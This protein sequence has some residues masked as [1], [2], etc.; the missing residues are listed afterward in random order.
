MKF[1]DKKIS[2][3]YFQIYI[4]LSSKEKNQL[5]KNAKKELIYTKKE[6]LQEQINIYKN[7]NKTSNSDSS[8]EKLNTLKEE[9]FNLNIDNQKFDSKEIQELMCD[10]LLPQIFD[11]MDENHLIQVFDKELSIIG[12]LEDNSSLTM[13]YSFCYIRDDY[14]LIYPTTKGNEYF[15]TEKDI[16]MLQTELLIMNKLYEKESAEKVTEFSDIVFS[17]F[18][19]SD[20]R[21]NLFMD[22][23]EIESTLSINRTELIGLNKDKHTVYNNNGRSVIIEILEIY[24]KKV[25]EINDEIVKKINYENTRTVIDLRKKIKK[26]FSFI[27][28]MKSNVTSILDKTLDL[29]N[30]PID[31]YIYKHYF[32][33]IK[34]KYKNVLNMYQLLDIKLAFFTSY[35]FYNYQV[36]LQYYVYYIEK[37]YDLL[38]KAKNPNSTLSLEDF[39][40]MRVPHYVLYDFFKSK[41][42]VTERSI[43]E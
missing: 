36:D 18:N 16:D 40:R 37:E 11:H 31:D 15:F 25:C 20:T 41:N 7:I 34:R 39:L 43:D 17:Y 4:I 3:S 42:L 30:F 23:N 6:Q 21:L 32:K 2:E 1:I 10:E 5:V 35:V 14:E 24:N 8:K 9:Y 12:S 19:E 38:Y 27:Y 13:I 28:N 22:I 33:H 29:N 26:I